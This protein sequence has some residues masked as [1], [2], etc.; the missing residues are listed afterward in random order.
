MVCGSA[1][2]NSK[3]LKVTEELCLSLVVLKWMMRLKGLCINGYALASL[4]TKTTASQETSTMKVK[5]EVNSYRRVKA[6]PLILQPCR[7]TS[8][9]AKQYHWDQ[10]SFWPGSFNCCERVVTNGLSG[11]GFHT[12][13]FTILSYYRDPLQMLS[14]FLIN[15]IIIHMHIHTHT[16]YNGNQWA[17]QFNTPDII[18][19]AVLAIT[20]TLFSNHTHQFT[21]F[22]R[23]PRHQTWPWWWS[24]LDLLRALQV[25]IH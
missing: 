1:T 11:H 18:T 22:P 15:A 10:W 16:F 6:A 2:F 20:N 19:A 21:Y 17:I 12:R 13:G 14:C 25:H 5:E 23:S 4:L 3:S 8:L 24:W 7:R 9:E